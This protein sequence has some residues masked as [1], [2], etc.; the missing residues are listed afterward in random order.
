VP[1]EVELKARMSRTSAVPESWGSPAASTY[2]DV[3]YD[4]ADGELGRGGR[5]LRVR[6]IKSDDGGE[7]VLLTYK[8]ARLDATSQPEH[9]TV[10]ADAEAIAAVLDGLGYTPVLGFQKQ[11]ANYRFSHRGRSITA[12]V[13]RLPE[14]SDDE[15]FVEIETLVE[16]SGDVADAADTV[17]AVLHEQLG[18]GDDDVTEELYTDAVRRRR[19][20]PSQ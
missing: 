3:Y 4:T 15:T 2:H 14:V 7:R 11:C 18:L 5:E 13:V 1:I 16:E 20:Q 8:G 19:G 10:V 9:E 6:V 12:T 17:R